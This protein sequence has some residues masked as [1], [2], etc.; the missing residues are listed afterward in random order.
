MYIGSFTIHYTPT[1]HYDAAD[2]FPVGIIAFELETGER[3]T[4]LL[5]PDSAAAPEWYC[6]S[7]AR[8]IEE[9]INEF[10]L[11]SN[12]S[13]VNEF[14]QIMVGSD[15]ELTLNRPLGVSDFE[16]GMALLMQ[17][18]VTRALGHE[19]KTYETFSLDFRT[20]IKKDEHFPIAVFSYCAPTGEFSAAWLNDENPFEPARLNR[21]QRK[22]IQR[23]TE[24]FMAN[25][26]SDNIQ[27]AFNNIRRPQFG[28]FKIDEFQAMS[29]GQ[30]LDIAIDD[31]KKLWASRKAA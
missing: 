15:I 22:H 14:G 1:E 3:I 25:M 6:E 2:S 29:S 12:T 9:E 16:A 30:A 7:L 23:Q 31:L 24:E 8:D 26:D 4:R 19:Y 17:T 21:S 5:E 10:L 20:N 18:Y 27:I 13:L 28:I 11:D